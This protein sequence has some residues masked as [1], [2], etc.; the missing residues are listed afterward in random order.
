MEIVTCSPNSAREPGRED[1]TQGA[2][3]TYALE[4]VELAEQRAGELLVLLL[5]SI[6][7]GLLIRGIRA[8]HALE[9]A[10]LRWTLD[11]CSVASSAADRQLGP[12]IATTAPRTSSAAL[13]AVRRFI[14]RARRC[15][16]LPSSGPVARGR[17]CSLLSDDSDV[18]ASHL[19]PT[20]K[21]TPTPPIHSRKRLLMSFLH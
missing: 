8:S 7:A 11:P 2:T 10:R 17:R 15:T 12:H 4:S 13:C 1:N 20:V 5:R 3:R 19:W 16:R 14:A 6:R 21:R 18:E 9:S